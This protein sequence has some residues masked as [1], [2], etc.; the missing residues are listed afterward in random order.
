VGSQEIQPDV[1]DNS[2]IGPEFVGAQ[3]SMAPRNRAVCA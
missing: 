2:D 1:V 3:S